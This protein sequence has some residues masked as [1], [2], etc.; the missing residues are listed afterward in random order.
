MASLRIRKRMRLALIGQLTERSQPNLRVVR[1]GD[2]WHADYFYDFDN[3][4]RNLPA[5]PVWSLNLQSN[6]IHLLWLPILLGIGFQVLRTVC[7][8]WPKHERLHL[9]QW[10]MGSHCSDVSF[11]IWISDW[12]N[13]IAVP[14][15]YWAK[16]HSAPV[17]HEYPSETV[18]AKV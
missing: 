11:S 10:E 14:F 3:N 7:S 17:F 13:D 8:V 2:L 5:V 6:F 1:K 16:I 9:F 4:C 15:G 18:T 12:W